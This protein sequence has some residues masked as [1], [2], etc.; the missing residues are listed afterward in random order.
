[1]EPD[2]ANNVFALPV[3]VLAPVF[4]VSKA[5]DTNRVAGTIVTYTLSVTN[6][7][8]ATAT[9]AVLSDTLPAGLTYLDSDGSHDGAGVAWS[10][11]GIAGGGGTAE[12]WFSARLQ[13]Q[14]GQDV[15]NDTY[16]VVRSDQGVRAWGDPVSFTTLTP[17][18]G[19]T[20][21]HG[22]E[23]ALTGQ[24]VYFTATATTD[25]TPL[26]YQWDLGEGAAGGGLTASR[27]FSEAGSYEVSVAVTD[28]CGYAKTALATVNVDQSQWMTFL[29]VVIKNN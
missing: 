3:T 7:G 26:N 20:L 19:I 18:I 9:G 10:L 24:T 15:V 6:S 14:A 13:C 1:M 8:N 23:P 22:P 4:D 5:Y 29:P 27:V 16:G 28:T 2:Y 17:T 25:G 21:A 11:A 12:G